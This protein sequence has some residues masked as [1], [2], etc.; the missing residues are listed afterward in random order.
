MEEIVSHASSGTQ[1]LS[2]FGA[3]GQKV[4]VL[5]SIFCGT[6]VTLERISTAPAPP[7]LGL[8]HHYALPTH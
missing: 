7:F 3:L 5:L 4:E 8:P 1:L 6:K 2:I